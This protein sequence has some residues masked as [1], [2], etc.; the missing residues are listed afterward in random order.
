MIQANT[1][2]RWAR[3]SQSEKAELLGIYAS[4]GYH[5]LASIIAHYNS[6]GGKLKADGGEI[7]ELE[8]AIIVDSPKT[9][10]GRYKL[11]K[12]NLN[13][14]KRQ[15]SDLMKSIRSYIKENGIFRDDDSVAPF[16]KA[17]EDAPST[18][19]ARAEFLEARD[20]YY[21]MP[22][23]P[24]NI[25]GQL[26]R[27]WSRHYGY[28]SKQNGT[29]KISGRGTDIIDL[30]DNVIRLTPESNQS[31]ALFNEFVESRYP[32][33]LPAS[34][35]KNEPD[36]IVGDKSKFPARNISIYGGIEDGM[37]KL[38]SL[39]NFNDNTTIIPARNIK[40]GLPLISKI[41]IKGGNDYDVGYDWDKIDATILL[42]SN[43]LR[44][45][46]RLFDENISS[47]ELKNL[48][49]LKIDESK[50][51]IKNLTEE[52]DGNNRQYRRH[53]Y[54]ELIRYDK[55]RIR[56]SEK[57]LNGEKLSR[58][59]RDNLLLDTDVERTL[60]G[61][62]PMSPISSSQYM[63]SNEPSKYTFLDPSGEEHLISD[64][65]AGILDGKTVLANPNGGIFVGRIQ[66]ISGPQ[67]DSL[68][69]YLSKNPSWLFRPDLGSF[70]QYRLD[71][72]SL[73]TYL[74][75]FFEHPREDDPNVYTIGTTEPNK[76]WNEKAEGGKI[77]IKPENR[78]KFTALKKRT[79]HSA[80]WFK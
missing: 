55:E 26:Y 76:L 44:S 59:E 32:S 23:D 65:N 30:K 33:V 54:N 20:N 27:Y 21:S 67:L 68:N 62:S 13:N 41:N 52:R 66:D 49:R 71:N 80:S 51:N 34:T 37:F 42:N 75:Q 72:P 17:I 24:N 39:S 78:G 31:T 57:L 28:K 18:S 63:T 36:R 73:K 16:I 77:H 61:M 74:K 58:N 50:E 64:Y 38:D 22:E 11:A 9:S 79:G 45:I 2:N 35:Y 46:G 43:S 8:P 48:A 40:S 14:A 10:R 60:I 29:G 70:S 6:C 3:L 56:A 4:K 12:S 19:Q 53:T 1:N 47:D 5:D 69:S 15:H 25:L 7:D